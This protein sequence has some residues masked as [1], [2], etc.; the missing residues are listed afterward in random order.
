[1]HRSRP[2]L[3]EV[4]NNDTKKLIRS[5]PITQVVYSG[6]NPEDKKCFVYTTKSRA[7]AMHTHI[8]MVKEKAMEIPRAGCP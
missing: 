1:M 5:S 8:F 2:H 6:I 3:L 7:G 4:V